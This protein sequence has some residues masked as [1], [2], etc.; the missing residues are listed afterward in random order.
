M[1]AAQTPWDK[2]F[3]RLTREADA[4]DASARAQLDVLAQC[5]LRTLAQPPT[6]ERIHA[7]SAIF[8][9]K[10][11]APPAICDWLV[12]RALP[13][14]HPSVV[15]NSRTGEMGADPRR[16]AMNCGVERDLITAI[17]QQRAAWLT[18]A[19]VSHYEPPNVISYEPGQRFDYH[20]DYIDPSQPGSADEL[21]A[22]GQ[23]VVTIVT[24]L[25]TEFDGAA[26]DF[27]RLGFSFRG[28]KGDAIMFAN[29]L[30]SGAPDINTLHAGLPPAAGRKW[31]LSQ[32]IRARPLPARA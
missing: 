2:D 17:M 13:R 23:R 3:S 32:W 8:A 19:P 18:G 31:V 1:D 4:G 29:V 5:D 14:L 22:L 12:A 6:K 24:Y 25:N 9:C 15:H 11:F 7:Q 30:P 28:E 27:P 10:G 16:T 21:A 26:T 20:H